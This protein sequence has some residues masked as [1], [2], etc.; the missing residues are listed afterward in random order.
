[1]KLVRRLDRKLRETRMFVRAMQSASHP[2][3]AQIVPIRR[4]NLDCAYCNEYDKTSAPV[5][6][7]TMLARIDRLADLGATII[8][9]SGGEPTLHPDLD[10]II[11]RIR[12]QRNAIATLITNGLLLTPDRIRA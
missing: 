7:E 3:L 2:I 6:L 5:P 8:T 11:S 12:D 10:A 1:M 4:C 9:L